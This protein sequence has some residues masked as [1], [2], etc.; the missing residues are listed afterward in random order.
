MLYLIQQIT[1]KGYLKQKGGG[2]NDEA[3]NGKSVGIS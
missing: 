2:Y 1:D 3:S